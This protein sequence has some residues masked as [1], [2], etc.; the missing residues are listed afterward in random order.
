MSSDT[1]DRAEID[2]TTSRG[3]LKRQIDTLQSLRQRAETVTRSATLNITSGNV[4]DVDPPEDIDEL[5]DLYKEIGLIRKNINTFVSD[6]IEP[7]ARVEAEDD[8]TQAYFEG[9]ENAPESAPD[10]GFLSEAF[11]LDEKRQPFITGLKITV[12]NRWTR[13]TILHE[14]LKQEE[15]NPES[16]ITGFKHI[17][18]ETVSAR[19]YP[20]TNILIDPEDTENADMITPR[21]EAAAYVQFDEQSILGRRL[22]RDNSLSNTPFGTQ[23]ASVPLSQNDVLK[24]TLDQDIGGS[25]PESGVFGESIIKAIKDDAEEYRSI[26][27]DGTTAVKKKAWGIWTFEFGPEVIEAGDETIVLEWDDDQIQSA[28]STLKNLGPGDYFTSDAKIGLDRH[29]GDVPELEDMLSHYVDDIIAPLP[30]PKYLTA[31]EGDINQFVTEAQDPRYQKLINE[32]RS[33]QEREWT[34]AFRLIA[35]RHPDLD[36]TGLKLKLEPPKDDSPIMSLD[37]DTV[38]RISTFADALDKVSGN[39]DPVAIFG[40][41]TIREL[42]LQLPEEELDTMS[43]DFGDLDESD[44]EVRA[45]FDALT[46]D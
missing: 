36:P 5:H 15:D 6:V 38:D 13:G 22:K 12:T 40:E 31:H 2:T 46:S 11:M 30:A 7:G 4:E 3:W 39:S 23:E 16:I 43:F 26:K 42:I 29:D 10:D 25:D 17:R 24:Q 19:T 1:Y 44:S 18:P 34:R 28:E 41:Q 37:D 21:G 35:E 32:E 14:F 20:N 45:Q 33:Y 8:T 27:R 9:G